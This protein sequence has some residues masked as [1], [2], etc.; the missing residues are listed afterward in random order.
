MLIRVPYY[1]PKT[2]VHSD[3]FKP[4]ER[5]IEDIDPILKMPKIS[6]TNIR[7]GVPVFLRDL[8]DPESQCESYKYTEET[9]YNVL[10]KMVDKGSKIIDTYME[11]KTA[12]A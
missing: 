4:D 2:F 9:D 7:I 12:H 11:N 8:Y 3:K 10:K 6:T 1:D 5:E